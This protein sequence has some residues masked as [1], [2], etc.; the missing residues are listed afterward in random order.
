VLSSCAH[1]R[2][3]MPEQCSPMPGQMIC[4]NPPAIPFPAA[5]GYVCYRPEEIVPFL[6]RCGER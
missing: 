5:G 4:A 2:I 1:N 6:E 3:K